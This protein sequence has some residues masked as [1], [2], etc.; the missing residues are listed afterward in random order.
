M[1]TMSRNAVYLSQLSLSG[2]RTYGARTEIT[3]PAAPSLTVIVG[4]NGLGK[5]TLFDAIEWGMTGALKRINNIDARQNDKLRSIGVDPQVKLLFSD[6]TEILRAGSDAKV[7][8]NGTPAAQS[9]ID[10][11]LIADATWADMN[12]IA[13]C[14][15]FTHFLGQSTKQLFVHQ[16][17]KVRWSRMAGP[18]GLQA[19]WEMERKLG[20][21]QTTIGFDDLKEKLNQ[22][23]LQTS[24]ELEKFKKIM[25][26]MG[27][28]RELARSDAAISPDEIEAG[29]S[30]IQHLLHQYFKA[31]NL[32]FEFKA[33]EIRLVQQQ[34]LMEQ[35]KDDLAKKLMQLDE[36]PTLA[37]TFMTYSADIANHTKALALAKENATHAGELLQT[38]QASEA[39]LREERDA[40]QIQINER[41]TE[42]S[43]LNQAVSQRNEVAKINEENLQIGTTLEELRKGLT[44][45]SQIIE[46]K[47]VELNALK[48][49][50]KQYGALRASKRDL[51]EIQR[52]V[53]TLQTRQMQH[54]TALL[55]ANQLAES[56]PELIRKHD[57]TKQE[58]NA[59]AQELL[60]LDQQWQQAKVSADTISQAVVQIAGALREEDCACPVCQS[61]FLEGE[62]K[63]LAN[64]SAALVNGQLS[65]I[66]TLRQSKLPRQNLLHLALEEIDRQQKA[67]LEAHAAVRLAAEQAQSL[68][69]DL[70]AKPL[71]TLFAV[72]QFADICKVRLAELNEAIAAAEMEIAQTRDVTIL[73]S[74]IANL[75]SDKNSVA[76]QSIAMTQKRDAATLRSAQLQATL[77]IFSEQELADMDQRLVALSVANE[78]AQTSLLEKNKSV[79]AA[80]EASANQKAK[81][82]M[83]EAEAAKY[84]SSVLSIVKL[85]QGLQKRWQDLNYAGEPTPERVVEASRDQAEQQIRLHGLQL[86]HERLLEGQRR[87]S[88][89]TSVQRIEKE[90]NQFLSKYPGKSEQEVKDFLNNRIKEKRAAQ[91]NLTQVRA[92]RDELVGA[93]RTNNTSI[94]DGITTPLNKSVARFCNALMVDRN[95]KVNVDAIASATTAQALLSFQSEGSEAKKNLELY[96]SEGQLAA[97]SLCLLFGAATTYPWSRWKALLLDDPLHH[98]DTIHSAAF[99]DVIR[100]LIKHQGYQIVVSTHDMEQAGYFLRKC[101]NAGIETQYWHLYGRSNDSVLMEPKPT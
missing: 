3:L 21:R 99:V 70:R 43:K 78:Q 71:L 92:K 42:T 89:Q 49:Q 13:D 77:A 58:L 24:E 8:F 100:N 63:A 20:R 61:S 1:N 37:Q 86:R 57:E 23:I 25:D 50:K 97:V 6:S 26:D 74:T 11:W 51:E 27:L 30:E 56:E 36:W 101:A 81:H 19:L 85:H 54:Q 46:E 31:E 84:E 82:A 52:N 79:D 18:S 22:H 66:E 45:L 88:A 14:L 28:Q 40:I 17:G 69:Q 10:D 33:G 53:A 38:A 34:M 67:I 59:L 94:R 2:F 90:K 12:D 64:A 44:E 55:Q 41:L 93:M 80:L 29:I 95:L 76:Q 87:Y 68:E 35:V 32:V 5:S 16:E 75:E 65:Q 15:H 60:G 83:L 7:S 62:L 39:S 96:L 72:D 47:N 48:E 91:D 4:P 98:N 9:N 73:E